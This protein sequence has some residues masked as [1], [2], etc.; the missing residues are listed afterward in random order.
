MR[1]LFLTHRLPY[2][3]DRG[4]RLRAHHILR[5]LASEHE[6]D[7]VSLVH[8]PSEQAKTALLEGLAASV[9]S[10]RVPRLRN[11]GRGLVALS[12]SQP[13]THVLL[14]APNV[15][16][17]ISKL[18]DKRPP[19]VVLAYCSS[20]AR[21]ALEEPLRRIPFVLDMLDVDSE[22]WAALAESTRSPKR[23]IYAREARHLARFELA[24]TRRAYATFVVNERERATLSKMAPGAH[25][26][27]LPNG[28]D[29]AAFTP[30]GPPADDPCVIFSGVMNYPPNEQA[31]LWLAQRVWPLVRARRPDAHLWLVGSD[32]THAVRRLARRDST[33]N[34]TGRVKDVRPYFWRSAVAVA[35][36]MVARG[37]QNKVLEAL[38]AGLPVV[39]TPPVFDG[40]P[41]EVIPGCVVAESAEAFAAAICNVLDRTADARRKWSE[42]ANMSALSWPDRL[43]P[44]LGILESA[45]RA[46]PAYSPYVQTHDT[47]RVVAGRPSDLRD[48]LITR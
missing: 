21:F 30:P 27:V 11:I 1:I 37:I 15:T 35:P 12:G 34:V 32:P 23:W 13:L 44:L 40:L 10:I 41:P 36:L 45:A 19:D 7:L 8:D 25:I 17:I 42:R 9:T 28:I 31:A 20:M 6:V 5:T 46:N 16:R 14:N 18:V 48:V 24:A 4:D 3:P 26:G 29:H 2:A 33:V 38:A 47:S 22:K 43:A 39:V